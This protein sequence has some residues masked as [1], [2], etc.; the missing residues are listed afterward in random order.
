M[1]YKKMKKADL[2]KELEKKPTNCHTVQNCVFTGV[3]WDEQA[4]EGV[5]TVAK[6]LLNLTELYKSQNI[7]IDCML[8][9]ESE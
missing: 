6:A 4:I 9:V 2:V 7:E 3:K 1:D 8:K 5:N